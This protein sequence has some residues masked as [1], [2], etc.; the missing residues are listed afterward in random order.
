M[1]DGKELQINQGVQARVYNNP[2]KKWEFGKV[3][4]RTGKL[5]YDVRIH[6]QLHRRH[7]DQLI[8][9]T[10]SPTLAVEEF[11]P[12]ECV[13]DLPKVTT[14]LDNNNRYSVHDNDSNS[15]QAPIL[16]NCS[17]PTQVPID[18]ETTQELRRS[19]R[20]RKAPDRLKL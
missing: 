7:R 10:G 8:P 6:D 20:L 19:T 17:S 18:N 1:K 9:Y 2:E 16:G 4:A 12:D 11:F 14:Q 5:H 3:V 15:V 13:S